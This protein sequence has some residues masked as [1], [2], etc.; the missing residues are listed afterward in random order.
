MYIYP[1]NINLE[2]TFAETYSL[3]RVPLIIIPARAGNQDQPPKRKERNIIFSCIRRRR[4][5]RDGKQDS[6]KTDVK[7]VRAPGLPAGLTS[8]EYITRADEREKE[9]RCT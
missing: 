2:I 7:P 9:R 3:R 4:E 5:R 6:N 1:K 8:G